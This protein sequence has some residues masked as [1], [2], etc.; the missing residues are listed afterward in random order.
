M[1]LPQPT[2]RSK[3]TDQILAVDLG[4]CQTKALHLQRKGQSW[5]LVNLVTLDPPPAEKARTAETLGEHFKAILSAL[6]NPRVKH[7]TVALGVEEAI[8]KQIELPMMGLEDVRQLLKM[9]SKTYL[10]QELTDHI[11]DCVYLPPRANATLPS[12]EPGAKPTSAAQQKFKVLVS[13]APRKVIEAIQGGAKIAGLIPES[14]VPSLIA[15]ANAFECVEPD[16]FNKEVVGLVDIGFKH[17]TIVILDAGEIVLNRVVSLGGERLTLG[18]AEAMGIS[19]SEAEGIKIGMPTEIQQTLDSVINPLGRELRASLDFFEHQHDRP[20]TQV[21]ISGGSAKNDIIIQALQNELMVPCRSWNP[22]RF[23]QVAVPE[24][25][26]AEVEE[27]SPQLSV[28]VG[29]SVASF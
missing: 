5:T 27:M 16:A 13:G 10:Q 24:G 19:P 6:G 3:R 12:N 4:G 20:I 8:L 17:S 18:L 29:A 23:L 15:P 22:I 28:A 7:L 11:F 21:F 2:Q 25:K 1:G 9:N 26:T 14:I